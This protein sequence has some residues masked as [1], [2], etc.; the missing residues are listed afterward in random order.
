MAQCLTGRP[1]GCLMVPK[2]LQAISLGE[3]SVPA[4]RDD[5]EV[6]SKVLGVILP[7]EAS[8]C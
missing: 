2:E 4:V 5:A 7:E 1:R 3:P 8:A 6:S